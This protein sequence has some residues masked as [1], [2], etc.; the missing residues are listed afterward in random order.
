M[1]WRSTLSTTAAPANL[2]RFSRQQRSLAAPSRSA[3]F[4][5]LVALLVV[6]GLAASPAFAYEDELWE[7]SPSHCAGMW[8]PSSIPGMSGKNS[9]IS[10]KFS[11]MSYPAAFTVLIYNYKDQEKLINKTVGRAVTC[12][13]PKTVETGQCPASARGQ[14]IVQ[15]TTTPF[16]APILNALVEF[17]K[18]PDEGADGHSAWSEVY[19]VGV[20][21]FYCVLIEPLELDANKTVID[22]IPDTIFT[23]M[24]WWDNPYGELPGSEYPKLP[25]FGFLALTYFV[26][27]CVWLFGAWRSWKDL[28]MLQHFV[29]AVIFF[30]VVEMAFNYGFYAYYNEHGRSSFFLLVMVVVLNAGRISISFFMLLIVALGYGVVRPTLGSNMTKCLILTGIHF[31]SGVLYATGSL[32]I[33]DVTAKLAV[34]FALPLSATMTAFY[35]FTLQGLGATMRTLEERKQTVKLTMYKNLRNILVASLVILLLFF[36]INITLFGERKDPRLVPVLWK[37]KWFLLDGWLN[38]L[39]FAV[40]VSIAY[41]W[42]PTTNNERYGLDELASD[43]FDDGAADDTENGIKLQNVSRPAVVSA[44]DGFGGE[45]DEK[46]EDL[47]RWAEEN[48]GEGA[49]GSSSG[50]GG[51]AAAGSSR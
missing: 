13:E 12:G 48:T 49:G 36:V 32:V 40:F 24:V 38:T 25:F 18:A 43:D 5:L 17:D 44:A 10:V 50:G 4:T 30:L 11:E 31:V 39:Y 19:A 7:H 46:E 15:D 3:I 42:R 8:S 28:L 23:A 34:I 14:F 22:V 37:I 41:L 2:W 16:V 6:S 33:T 35:F 26:I 51:G 45:D 47:F 21:G 1:S 27:G 20:T 29:T 9:T